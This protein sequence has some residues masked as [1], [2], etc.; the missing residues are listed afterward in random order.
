MLFKSFFII[1]SFESVCITPLIATKDEHKTV[2]IYD[3]ENTQRISTNGTLQEITCLGFDDQTS[4]MGI[5]SDYCCSFLSN[6]T[7]VL[8]FYK[9]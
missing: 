2:M 3:S 1:G 5:R 4:L 6:S 8:Y 9:H 7:E